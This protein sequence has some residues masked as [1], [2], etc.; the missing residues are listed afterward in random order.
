MTHMEPG[1]DACREGNLGQ[2][3]VANGSLGGKSQTRDCRIMVT[4]VVGRNV[5]NERRGAR[6]GRF[7]L[8]HDWNV[9]FR[10]VILIFLYYLTPSRRFGLGRRHGVRDSAE[11]TANF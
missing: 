7:R 1:D 5:R 3:E 4:R 9:T 11:K 2:E 10:H 6:L 8:F